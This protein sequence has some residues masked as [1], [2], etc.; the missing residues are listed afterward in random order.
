MG[1]AGNAQCLMN[2]DIIHSI[3]EVLGVPLA[4]YKCEGPHTLLEFL[5]DTIAMTISL[6]L[7]WP[8]VKDIITLSHD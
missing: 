7:I 3:C 4:K 2:C 6:G 8:G 5:L 1:L